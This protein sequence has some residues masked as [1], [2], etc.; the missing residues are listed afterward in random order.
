M[1]NFSTF[2]AD[3]M[4]EIAYSRDGMDRIAIHS[5]V[6]KGEESGDRPITRSKELYDALVL[7]INR[8]AAENE[9]N[10]DKIRTRSGDTAGDGGQSVPIGINDQTE[11]PQ[12]ETIAAF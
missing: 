6:A 2:I 3:T 1:I 4:V 8:E 11:T 5:I 10:F 12:T 9:G 7:I